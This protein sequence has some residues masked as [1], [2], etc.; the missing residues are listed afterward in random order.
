LKPHS[1]FGQPTVAAIPKGVVVAWPWKC[2][3]STPSAFLITF[4]TRSWYFAGTWLANRSGGSIMWSSML[5]RI[6]S[7]SCMASSSFPR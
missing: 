3:W 2:H 4:G 1:S 6:I 5:T 7:S